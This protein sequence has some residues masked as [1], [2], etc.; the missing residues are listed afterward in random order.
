MTLVVLLLVLEAWLG[1]LQFFL[2]YTL[3][4]LAV[5]I[6]TGLSYVFDDITVYANNIVS[7]LGIGLSVDYSLF[8]VNRFRGA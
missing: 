2:G 7:L 8:I 3:S 4:Y 1:G 6:V 5:G